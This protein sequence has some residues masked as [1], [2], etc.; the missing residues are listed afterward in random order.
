L[1]IK[2]NGAL[3]VNSNTGQP[4]QVLTSAGNSGPPV[5]ADAGTGNNIQT[6]VKN[7]TETYA[8]HQAILNQSNPGY[9]FT[10][11]MHNLE[12][13]K[14]SRLI[15]NAQ[16]DLVGP[17]CP[18]GCGDGYATFEIIINGVNTTFYL[19]ASAPHDKIISASINNFMYDINPGNY[20]LEFRV[21][22]QPGSDLIIWGNQSSVIVV[23]L[24]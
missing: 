12:I 21:R 13:T 5:W 22:L 15:I 6:Y 8:G 18:I 24:E 4:G 9:V 2:A 19:H 14:K 16:F 3:A 10:A 7:P 23:P 20:L 17:L 1:A 11:L